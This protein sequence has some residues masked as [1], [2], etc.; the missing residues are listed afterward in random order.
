MELARLIPSNLDVSQGFAKPPADAPVD[1]SDDDDDDDNDEGS[2]VHR[3]KHVKRQLQALAADGMRFVTLRNDSGFGVWG[4]N[5]DEL[6]RAMC[7]LEYGRVCEQ[8]FGSSARRVL[9]V[10][11]DTGMMDEKQL[12]NV[13]LVKQTDIRVL[14][15]S[16]CTF[17]ALDVQEVPRG[18]DRAPSKTFFL[19][20]HKPQ[21][22]YATLCEMIK[23]SMLHCWQRIIQGKQTN[24]S[25]ILHVQQATRERLVKSSADSAATPTTDGDGSTSSAAITLQSWETAAY[26]EYQAVE[27]RLWTQIQRMDS[28]LQLFQS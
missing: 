1:S 15:T 12:A 9:A 10:I 23:T 4:V 3:V 17:G 8:K 19:W 18:N 22:T 7:K 21:R 13:A 26:N 2:A 25:V 6:T 11:R 5:F 14:L 27:M 20:Y 28:M 24:E 16:L